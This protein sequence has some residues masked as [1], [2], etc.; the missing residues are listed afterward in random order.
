MSG[1]SREPILQYVAA[2]VRRAR[3]RLHLTQEELA[4]RIGL[5]DERYIQ[6]IESGTVNIGL[7][8]LSRIAD[9]LSVTPGSLLKKAKLPEPKRGRP[10]GTGGK[11]K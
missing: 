9:V 5:K 11:G 4:A 3:K 1:T 7:V 8:M 10:K 2:N 6:R